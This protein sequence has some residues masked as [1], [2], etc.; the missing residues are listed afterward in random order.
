MKIGITTIINKLFARKCAWA[1]SA[2]HFYYKKLLIFFSLSKSSRKKR[3]K[4][5]AENWVESGGKFI[6]QPQSDGLCL[7]NFQLSFMCLHWIISLVHTQTVLCLPT[8]LLTSHFV[9]FHF[10][11]FPDWPTYPNPQFQHHYRTAPW[12]S[13][14]HLSTA[15]SNADLN[16]AF[17]HAA[18][19]R[20]DIS[21]HIS[22][23]RHSDMCNAL[24]I[25]SPKLRRPVV[26]WKKNMW[27]KKSKNLIM[28]NELEVE[29][30]RRKMIESC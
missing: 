24:R 7:F 8:Y 20:L 19:K 18:Q 28:N 27:I 22:S 25:L 30:E 12:H 2:K 1:V 14:R 5:I 9:S 11:Q 29:K 16:F 23:Y 4:K 6:A 17:F 3:R 10:Q 21:P 15:R 13:N 26:K